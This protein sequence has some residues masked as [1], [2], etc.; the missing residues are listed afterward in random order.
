MKRFFRFITAVC[1]SLFAAVQTAFPVYAQQPCDWSGKAAECFLWLNEQREVSDF[2]DGL[3][4]GDL[5]WAAY[6]RAR[7]Y[8]SK[9]AESY[10]ESAEARV[11]ELSETDGFVRPTELHRAAIVLAALGGDF[12]EAAEQGVFYNQQ[13]DRQG[14]NAYIWALITL[15]V[16][17]A[18][19]PE[20]A[21]NI[22]QSLSD[23]IMFRQHDDGSFSLSGETGDTDIT[24]AAVYALAQSGITAA[25]Q[26]A[27][28]GADWLAGIDGMYSSMGNPTCE[29]AAQAVIAF[30][31]VGRQDLAWQAAEQ[32]ESYYR[33]GGYAHFADGEV[34][35]MA[36]VQALEAFTALELSERGQVIFSVPELSLSTFEEENQFVPDT[37]EPDLKIN[38]SGLSGVQITLILSVITGFFAV[39]L[40]AFFV[41][42]KSKIY[43]AGAVLLAALSGGVWLMDIRSPEEYYSEQPT[44]SLRVEV[45]AE[46]Q[47]ALAGINKIDASVN[48]PD[49]IP[50]DGIVLSRTEV[51]LPEKAT[52]FDALVE[53]ARQQRVRVD[54][55]GSSFGAYISGIG[56]IYELGFG[57][58]SGWM[59]RVNGEFPDIACG[60]FVLNEG[61]V[62]EFIYTCDL[63]SDIGNVYNPQ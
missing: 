26:A 42:R 58:T 62:V 6:C 52:A 13:L 39:L 59:Y 10:I 27:E 55:T 23:Y 33:N 30:C 46:C 28:R 48:P 61:D 32:L 5:D 4:F 22:R 38:S 14:F 17:G 19:E 63:G 49:V 53:A 3:S 16:T 37:D 20:N 29:S 56:G 35:G 25:E 36:V 51:L 44:G 18:E 1:L 43:C 9:G 45:M 40:M 24:A 60:S 57:D 41:F 2:W 34:N 8:G 7:L 11:A 12:S 31:S 21:L 47:A 15:N 54:Y 50:A